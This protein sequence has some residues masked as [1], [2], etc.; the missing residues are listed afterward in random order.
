MTVQKSSDLGRRV[1]WRDQME[2][3]MAMMEVCRIMPV[4][5]CL[6]PLEDLQAAAVAGGVRMDFSKTPFTSGVARVFWLRAGL[7]PR[8]LAAAEEMNRR[9]WIL[10]IE[11]GY[12]SMDM[13]RAIIHIPSVFDAIYRKTVWELDGSVPDAEMM[14]RRVTAL[15]ATRPK[16]GTHMSGS[17]LDISVLVADTGE[18]LDRGAPYLEMSELTPMASPFVSAA[19]Q[20]NRQAITDI[21]AGHGFVA[22]PFEF[23]H[24]SQGDVYEIY[25]Q[26]DISAPPPAR[27]GAVN[28][29]SHKGTVTPIAEPDAL[30]HDMSTIRNEINN[31][32][33]RADSRN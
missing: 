5:D 10:R 25:L 31:A 21:M 1:F 24:Y 18:I 8:L 3:A 16:F 12:R 13:Q 27:Y 2:A 15:V 29:D 9:G 20:R 4:Q 14:L 22:Y 7:V 17:A 26:D 30:L 6:E 23:W 28:W 33:Q 19:A 32:I 11:D